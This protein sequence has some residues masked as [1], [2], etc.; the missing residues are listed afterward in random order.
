LPFFFQESEKFYFFETKKIK[1]M[2]ADKIS[3][4]KLYYGL[5]EKIKKGLQYLEGTDFSQIEPG[6]YMLDG[7]NLFAAISEYETKALMEAKTE[8]HVNYID[9]QYIV[10]GEEHIGYLPF[11]GQEASVAYNP[12][13]DVAFYNCKTSP[14][15]LQA[16]DFAIFYPDDLHQPGIGLN[17]PSPVKKVV[18][19][20]RVD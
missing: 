9:I 17:G 6:K 13:K 1:E 20:I 18:V 15:Y 14:V 10:S 8:N 11:K 4:A 16:G 5:G 7:Q 12:E 3:N 2:V 19:K